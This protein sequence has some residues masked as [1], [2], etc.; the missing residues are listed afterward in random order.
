MRDKTK[1]AIIQNNKN[2]RK[3]SV[4]ARFEK[5]AD[6][7]LFYHLITHLG[8]RKCGRCIIVP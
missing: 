7:D 4:L 1:Y 3:R 8:R 6:R 2:V 5:E